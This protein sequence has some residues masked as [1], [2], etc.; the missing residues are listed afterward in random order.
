MRSVTRCTLLVGLFLIVGVA[1]TTTPTASAQQQPQNHT[2]MIVTANSTV[3]YSATAS[4]SLALVQPENPDRVTRGH[5]TAGSVGLITNNVLDLHDR[6][7]YSGYIQSFHHQG[8]VRVRIDG[9]D[10]NA[11]VISEQHIR[12]T[13]P[14]NSSGSQ[15][16]QYRISV[17][18]ATT[19]GE[20]TERNDTAN[21]STIQ[22]QISPSDPAD[23]FYFSGK[24]TKHSWKDAVVQINGQPAQKF[25]NSDPPTQPTTTQTG[26][27][28]DGSDSGSTATTS[29][30]STRTDTQNP[31]RGTQS[32]SGFFN[33]AFLIG[34]GGGFVLLIVGGVVLLMYI[35]YSA[36]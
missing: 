35:D 32:G 23:G 28:K 6:I 13:Y 4:Q 2:L 18:N 21:G 19:T 3:T 34:L 9:K 33:S 36:R 29:A 31:Q 5:R 22:G 12:I 8:K 11:S 14:T 10:V 25:L 15:P 7:H 30:P 17:S 1:A 20:D 16:I 24:I 27:Q 26:T